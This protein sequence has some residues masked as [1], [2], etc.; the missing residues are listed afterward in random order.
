MNKEL[1]S[2]FSQYHPS[3]QLLYIVAVLICAM[4]TL[5]PTYVVLSFLFGSMY[6]IFLNGLNKYLKGLK[7][8]IILFIVIVIVNPLTNHSG[9][10]VLFTVFDKNVTLEALLY[11]V[12]AGGMMLS[13]FVWFQ[14]Y[15]ALITN[16]KFMYLFGR[17][18]PTTAMIIS[19]ITRFV[20]VTVKKYHEIVYAQKGIQSVEKINRKKTTEKIKTGVRRIGILMSRCLEDSLETADSMRARGYGAEKR[21][22]FSKYVLKKRDILSLFLIS[23]LLI[24]LIIEIIVNN[25]HFAFFPYLRIPDMNAVGIA[26]KIIYIILLAY[27]LIIEAKDVWIRE[28]ITKVE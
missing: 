21:T 15:Q 2:I 24:Y 9:A 8:L 18:A 17:V 16:D 7:L 14:C 28:S 25:S 10:T 26:K 13:I 22:Q 5:Q 27:P 6:S 12:F 3:V 4:L 19:M 1:R 20:P 23:G 11:G